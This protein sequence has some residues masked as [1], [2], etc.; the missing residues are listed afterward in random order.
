[1]L[2]GWEVDRAS[3]ESV[4]AMA[5]AAGIGRGAMLQ[6]IIDAVEITEDGVPTTWT[7]I[8]RSWLRDTELPID[9]D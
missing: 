3:R 5:A 1:M 6:H 7:G 2:I 9:T 4:A 8:P